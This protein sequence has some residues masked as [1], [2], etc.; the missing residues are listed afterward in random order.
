MYRRT[1]AR[2]MGFLACGWFACMA[3]AQDR[4]VSQ[5]YSE[6]VHAYFAGDMAEAVRWLTA[7]IEKADHDPRAYFFR[8]A[9]YWAQGDRQKAEADFKAGAQREVFGPSLPYSLN[10]VLHRIQGTVRMRIEAAREAARELQ[11]SQEAARKAARYEALRRAKQLVLYPP[12]PLPSAEKIVSQLKLATLPR[13]PFVSGALFASGKRA[14]EEAQSK[15]KTIP[16]SQPVAPAGDGAAA[17]AAA[18]AAG[19][20]FGAP[21]GGN[22]FGAPA[23]PAPKKEPPAGDDPFG[24]SPFGN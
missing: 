19:D 9:A 21:A 10:E 1:R 12:R 3:A 16:V 17:P 13:D 8:G 14:P 24:D 2:I 23:K 7:T 15:L 22:P 20:P 5:T 11:R 18:P 4:T 6:G